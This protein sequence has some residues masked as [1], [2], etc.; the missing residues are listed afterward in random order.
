MHCQR[1]I[2]LVITLLLLFT[3]AL[4]GLSAMTT[5]QLQL[6]MSHNLTGILREFE[7]TESALDAI[8]KNFS[9]A[10]TCKYPPFV[11][12]QGKN[13]WLAPQHVSC[14]VIQTGIKMHYVVEEFPN[15]ICVVKN[16]QKLPGTYYRITIWPE[17]K[18]GEPT[19]LQS[20]LITINPSAHC[21]EKMPLSHAG[22]TS[23]RE[24]SG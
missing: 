21:I 12:E 7:I 3:L 8:E 20:T 10:N 24:L 13:P 14:T 19:V 15:E 23:W 1:G 18:I 6:H 16:L 22:R 9:P 17:V 2:I 11:K 5:S 4:L